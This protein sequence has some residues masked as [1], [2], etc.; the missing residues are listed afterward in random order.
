MRTQ[1]FLEPETETAAREAFEQLRSPA[2]E[3]TRAVARA[4]DLEGDDYRDHVDETVVGA[5]H[6]A[7]FGSLLTVRTADRETFEAWRD[8]QDNAEYSVTME[9][10]EHVANV[11]WHAAPMVE[12]VFAATYENERAAAVATLRR[13][14]W[15][16]IYRDRV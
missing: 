9:G 11:A 10:S 6:E 8:R 15:G 1:G 2:S 4:M 12:R 13:L 3:V 14:A 16:R 5:A 7:L